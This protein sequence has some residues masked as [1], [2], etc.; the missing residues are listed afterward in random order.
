VTDWLGLGAH[1]FIHYPNRR[2]LPARVR[3]FVNFVVD[4]LRANPDLTGDVQTLL[5]ETA[6]G[7]RDT[8]ELGA[9]K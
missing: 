3:C 8:V 4:A 2:N 7:R 1:V 5:R 9:R 6:T